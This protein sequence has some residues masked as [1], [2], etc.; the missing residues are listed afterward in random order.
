MERFNLPTMSQGG[1]DYQNTAVLF[2]RHEGGFELNVV[3]WN[4]DGAVA[5]R[6]ASDALNK[7]FRL[8]KVGQRICRLF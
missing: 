3:P 2:R 4:D 6:A 8:G 5:W 7:V 1:F